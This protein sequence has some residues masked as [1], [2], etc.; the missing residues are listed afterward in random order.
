[1]VLY[2]PGPGEQEKNNYQPSCPALVL[3]DWSHGESEEATVN[4]RV[5]YDG[6]TSEWKTSVMHSALSGVNTPRWDYI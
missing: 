3:T 6:E 2:F 5:F 4:L 1:M